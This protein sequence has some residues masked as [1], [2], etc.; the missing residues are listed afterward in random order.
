MMMN[1]N[2][3]MAEAFVAVSEMMWEGIKKYFAENGTDLLNALAAASGTYT[4]AFIH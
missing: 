1:M 3:E 4:P 2:Y